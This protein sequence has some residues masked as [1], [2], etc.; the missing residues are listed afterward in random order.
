MMGWRLVY[1]ILWAAFI[2]SAALNLTH[3]R[4]GFL[5]SHLADLSVPALLYVLAREL[6][7]GNRL[8]PRQLGRIVGR[9]PETA[10]LCFFLA[11]TATEVSQIY[12]PHGPFSGRFDPLDIVAYGVGLAAC[13]G[14]ETIGKS[15]EAERG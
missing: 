12:W 7:P 10:A 6:V 9:T 4:G 14:A 11:S 5:T 15:R 3:I 13:Y 8:Y 1:W 2:L